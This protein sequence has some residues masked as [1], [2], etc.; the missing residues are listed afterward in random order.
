MGGAG[1]IVC[2]G[3]RLQ[4]YFLSTVAN[5]PVVSLFISLVTVLLLLLFCSKVDNANRKLNNPNA[6]SAINRCM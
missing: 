5:E 3:A 2:Y 1:W 6:F 4:Y